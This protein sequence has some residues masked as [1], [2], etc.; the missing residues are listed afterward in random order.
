MKILLE[1]LFEDIIGKA[2]RG[3]KLSDEEVATKAGLA[4]STLNG[5]RTGSGT[6][7]DVD[8]LARAL[9]LKPGPLWESFQRSWEPE[10]VDVDGLEQVNTDMLGFT[11]NTYLVWDPSS[12]SCALFDAGIEPATLFAIRDRRN[13]KVES[14]F[15]THTHEDHVAA[16]KEIAAKTSARLFGPS[17]EPVSGATAVE[18]GNRFEIGNLKIEARLTNG[19]SPGGISYIIEGLSVPVAVVGDS[20]FSGSM[21]GAPTAYSLALT[22]NREKLMTLPADTVIC[23]GHGPMTTV[24][25]EH[26]HNPF[27]GS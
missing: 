15:I 4:S 26:Q 9:E 6:R 13:L 25:E 17:R 7:A 2:Q 3:L 8:A 5:L 18:E 23:P 16:L 20:L 21:G 24:G 11:V 19:H 12:G 1:D 22:N 10:P 14:I 27:V